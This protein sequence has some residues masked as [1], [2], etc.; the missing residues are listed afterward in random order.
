MLRALL[1]I[2]KGNGV[3]AGLF[4]LLTINAVFPHFV[5][6]QEHGVVALYQHSSDESAAVDQDPDYGQAGDH[7]LAGD[8]CGGGCCAPGCCAVIGVEVA[9]SVPGLFAS[10]HVTRPPDLSGEGL[11]TPTA[12]RPPRA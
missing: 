1:R 4:A 9:L 6:C 5:I 7:T 11:A 8:S 12:E 3:I 2:M 10:T